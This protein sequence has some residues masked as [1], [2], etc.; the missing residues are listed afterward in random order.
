MSKK[1]NEILKLSDVELEELL[2]SDHLNVKS[3]EV[4]FECIV[5][6]IQ[7]DAKN[8]K[9]HIAKLLKCIRL[10]LLSTTYFIETVKVQCNNLIIFS[11]S[12][13][14]IIIQNSKTCIRIVVHVVD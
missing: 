9:Q 12:F 11:Y 10:G 7:H 3:E 1:G 2:S 14:F 13:I 6:W 4:V 8:R 5:R